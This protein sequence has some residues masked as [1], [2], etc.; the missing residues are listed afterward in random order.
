MDFVLL[1]FQDFLMYFLYYIIS[2]GYYYNM[3]IYFTRRLY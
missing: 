2:L 3:I 1:I